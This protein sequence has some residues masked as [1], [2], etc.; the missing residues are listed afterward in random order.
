ML[1]SRA[2]SINDFSVAHTMSLATWYLANCHVDMGGGDI[3]HPNPP[4]YITYL[5]AKHQAMYEVVCAT[6]YCAWKNFHEVLQ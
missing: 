6:I 5:A 2:V 3:T 1:P 4:A